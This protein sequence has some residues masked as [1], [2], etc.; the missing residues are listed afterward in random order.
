[1]LSCRNGERRPPV[2]TVESCSPVQLK[3]EGLMLHTKLYSEAVAA[4]TATPSTPITLDESTSG[5][6]TDTRIDEERTETT[7]TE[8]EGDTVIHVRAI[9]VPWPKPATTVVAV[10]K[11]EPAAKLPGWRVKD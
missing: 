8:E 4:D 11:Y 3:E 2:T 5:S 7:G 1:M 6:L 9:T 10:N